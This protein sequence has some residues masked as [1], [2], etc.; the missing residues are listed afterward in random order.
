MWQFKLT[1]RFIFWRIQ[2]HG[3]TYRRR[4]EHN[5]MAA[6]RKCSLVFTF[7]A[8]TNLTIGV[9]HAKFGTEAD[10]KHIVHEILF[11]SYEHGNDA[12]F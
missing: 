7:M 10:H 2:A 11:V 12:K 4:K 1:A 9:W 3:P 8:V 6:V 5:N